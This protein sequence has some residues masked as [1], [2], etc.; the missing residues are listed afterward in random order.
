MGGRKLFLDANPMIFAHPFVLWLLPLLMVGGVC[1][2]WLSKHLAAKRLARFGPPER[3]SQIVISVNPKAR[4]RKWAFVLTAL[5]LLIL[6]AARPMIGPRSLDTEQS[7]AE[8]FIALDVSKSMLV[9]DV[10]PDR[11]DAVKASLSKWLET[12]HGDRI[13][14]ILIAGDAFVQAPLTNDYTALR[15]VLAQTGHTS[16]SQGGTNLASAIEMAAAAFEATQARQKALIIVSDGDNLD[17]DPVSAAG[18][19]RASSNMSIFTVGVG[20]EAGG[21]VP[22]PAKGIA[23]DF[24]KPPTRFIRDEFGVTARSRLDERVLRN[25]AAAGGGQYFR[26]E[27]DGNFWETLYTEALKP[28]AGTMEKID[29]N[30]YD[31]LF[32][33]PLLLALLLLAAEMAISS[34]LANPPRLR[35]AIQIPE[36]D[37]APPAVKITGE[38]GLGLM[39]PFVA[40]LMLTMRTGAAGTTAQTIDG[41]RQLMDQGNPQQAAK[42]LWE[43]TQQQ[44]KDPYLIF[45]YGIASSASRD[46][47]GAISAFTEVSRHPELG[48]TAKLQLGNVHFRMGQEFRKSRNPAG[49]IVAW[50]RS[51]EFYTMVE[52]PDATTRHNLEVTKKLLAEVLFEAGSTSLNQAKTAQLLSTRL[53][54]SGSAFE[55]LEKAS[56][57]APEMQEVIEPR[58]E[59]RQLFSKSLQEK[60]EELAKQA[61][62]PKVDPRKKK[63]LYEEAVSALNK[64]IEIDPEN[65]ELAKKMEALRA[66]TAS[67]YAN[68]AEQQL[69]KAQKI[70]KTPD[71][72][73][74]RDQ[75]KFLNEAITNSNIALEFEAENAKATSVKNEALKVMEESLMANAARMEE[76]G[77]I[78]AALKKRP[79]SAAA[80]Y[81]TSLQNYQDALALNDTND[82]ARSQIPKI[83]DK[84]AE[85]LTLQAQEDMGRAEVAA[86][87][88]PGKQGNSKLLEGIGHLE[89][90]TQILGQAEAMAP[91]KNNAAELKGQAQQRLSELRNRLDQSLI[92]AAESAGEQEPGEPAAAPAE[93]PGAEGAPTGGKAPLNFSE[94]RG[95]TETKGD[96]SDKSRDGPVRDW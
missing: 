57:L 59:A 25:I 16:I 18:T 50:E 65:P 54:A 77:D 6:A 34:R 55:K 38:A 21:S 69:A 56:T 23:Q 88:P 90:A 75:Q 80:R 91:G 7:G 32:Q 85:Q 40:V 82:Q 83:Q 14:L 12:R 70:S 36:T 48:R 2:L 45:N 49:A 52:N 19:I 73:G 26:F 64:A 68:T 67:D 43:A 94:I 71:N 63:G 78:A 20:T 84:L 8:F 86:T 58:E 51:V 87:A 95:S 76:A 27:P 17:G 9:R 30:D 35:S 13:G 42:L 11:L 37:A 93:I 47:Q 46:F 28:M 22:V 15:E 61:A 33:I 81:T 66:A 41:A 72:V 89:K 1:L 31:D 96:F 10:E 39:I 24:S 5:G 79:D 92:A 3:L 53:E 4:M 62:H 74:F 60:S 29:V 44:T